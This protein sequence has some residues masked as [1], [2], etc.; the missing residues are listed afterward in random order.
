VS[1]RSR[2]T[3]FYS[4]GRWHDLKD[5]FGLASARQLSALNRAGCLELV[6]VDD[7]DPIDKAEAAYMVERAVRLG[8]LTPRQPRDDE[9]TEA[10]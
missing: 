1:R 3:T 2:L 8:R 4:R 9:A 7:A 10:P 6:D 5:P